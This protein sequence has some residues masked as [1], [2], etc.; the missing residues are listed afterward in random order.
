MLL[1]H[2]RLRR[3]QPAGSPG[4]SRLP[5]PE[6][7]R[8]MMSLETNPT[9]RD[10]WCRRLTSPV[11]AVLVLLLFWAGLLASLRNKGMTYDEIG[12]ATAGYS[13]WR[14]NDFRLDPENGNLPQRLMALP[15]YLSGEQFKFPPPEAPGWRQTDVW[16]LGRQ[17]FHEMGHDQTAML[18][19][20][21]AI[22]GLVAVVLGV[23]VWLWSRRL[24][25][26]AGGMLSLL[27]Y[28]LSPIILANGA[29]MTSDTI[30]A[31]FFLAAIW[32][33]W[34]M[35]HRVTP[36]RVGLA[37][38]CLGGLCVA[39]MSAILVVPMAL[40]LAVVR[41]ASGKPLVVAF[42]RPR[43]MSRRGQQALVF[44]AA[45]LVQALLA[46]VVIWGFYGFRYGAFAETGPDR[47]QFLRRWEMVLGK[48]DP[49][50]LVYQL[51]L[52]D[53]QRT[54]MSGLLP[55]SATPLEPWARPRVDAFEAIRRDIL[56]PAQNR[57]VDLWL[58]EPPSSWPARVMDFARRH[59]LLPEAYL[60]GYANVWRFSGARLGFLNGV[61]KMD[62]DLW[63]FPYAFLVKTPLTI[64]AIGGLALVAGIQ[65]GRRI[66]RREASAIP[67]SWPTLYD[68]LP[69]WAVLGLYGTT[70]LLSH[71]NIGHRHL[72][73]VYPPLI[74]LIGA[75]GYWLADVGRAHRA[76]VF[77]LSGLMTGLVVEMAWRFP[78]YLPYFNV[79]AGGP[80]QGYRHLVDSSLDWG[81]DLPGVKAYVDQHPTDGPY[82]LSYFG[83][84]DP[85]YYAIAATRLYSAPGQDVPPPLFILPAMPQDRADAVLANV[86]RL[87]PAYE[88][89][90][91]VPAANGW[92]QAVMLKNVRALHWTKGTYLI[93]AT[94]LQPIN[95]VITGPQG[96]WNERFERMYQELGRAVGPIYGDD[97]QAR[98][99][100]L[101]EHLPAEWENVLTNIEA[102]RFARLTAFLRKREPDGNINFSILVYHLSDAD[103]AQAL[104]GPPPELG[105][106]L[107][108]AIAKSQGFGE[109][110]SR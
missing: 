56:S 88:L 104:Q 70:I 55:V 26:P 38:L 108:A 53:G 22:M 110:K 58:A 8:R 80:A 71:L 101:R 77:T 49:V 60:Y 19:R 1:V 14:Y 11:A 91:L 3:P 59:E 37:G 73:A 82:Y 100:R 50:D 16:V 93:S 97:P 12:H 29:L 9:S 65:V 42:G 5:A 48:R 66:R 46:W 15:L 52:S 7:P 25:G 17:W 98:L 41:L 68:T 89:A 95:Y 24:F 31:L 96:P 83:M 61:T 54:Q 105:P 99:A 107:P 10:Q 27:L 43:E 40:L 109:K 86:Q 103:I 67:V 30:A 47:G 90:G 57:Q 78:N 28:V 18:F 2:P 64:L 85:A 74:V 13:Y 84:D 94:M 81:Q 79:I 6:L 75:A 44:V 23:L 36:G 72:L 92:V 33:L 102:F 62:G 20:G 35:L 106:D 87:Y 34:E 32:S 69:L 51:A 39:K 21:R 76:L 63:F 4:E 45:G